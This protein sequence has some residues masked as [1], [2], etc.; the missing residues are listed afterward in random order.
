M[1][2]YNEIMEKNCDQAM[3]YLEKNVPELAE[4]REEVRKASNGKVN[5][6][7]GLDGV[8]DKYSNDEYHDYYCIYEGENHPDHTVR[9]QTV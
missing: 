1:L 6:M 3:D 9:W 2:D 7:M 4:F 5:V 8:Q